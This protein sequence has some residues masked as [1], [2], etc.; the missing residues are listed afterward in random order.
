MKHPAIEFLCWFNKGLTGLTKVKISLINQK[1][2]FKSLT[3][4]FTW[5]SGSYQTPF[6]LRIP[7]AHVLT[8]LREKTREKSR[9]LGKIHQY[10]E[11]PGKA[12]VL[13]NIFRLRAG[14]GR[15]KSLLLAEK[16]DWK[17]GIPQQNG[18]GDNVNLR[19]ALTRIT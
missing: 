12:W 18:K 15:N 10:L 9:N 11:R 3:D 5:A 8:T 17:N 1:T 14:Q 7:R 19:R 13:S 4:P 2:R 6:P 16:T